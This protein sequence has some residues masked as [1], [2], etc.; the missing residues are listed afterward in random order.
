MRAHTGKRRY[1]SIHK[2]SKIKRD[3]KPSIGNDMFIEKDI[4]WR[5]QSTIQYIVLKT[6][7]YKK[8][9]KS[10]KKVR[11]LRTQ[12]LTRRT[13]NWRKTTK[14]KKSFTTQKIGAIT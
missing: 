3:K 8:R 14:D 9:L 4:K 13:Q 2:I 10:W 6:C 7:H 5:R 1:T 11:K 12:E